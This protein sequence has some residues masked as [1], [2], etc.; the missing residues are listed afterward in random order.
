MFEKRKFPRL[1]ESWDVDYR[2][3]RTEDLKMNIIDG[4]TVN[5]SGGGICFAS[6]EEIPKGTM[7]AVELK[8]AEFPSPIMALAKTIW[9]KEKD[10]GKYDIGVE[11][12]W[13]GWK[14]NDAQKSILDYVNV[15]VTK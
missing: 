6:N 5:I 1:G 14:N 12:W 3:I 7:L 15:Q 10:V 2:A 13:T 8:S 11:F 4:L 9:C